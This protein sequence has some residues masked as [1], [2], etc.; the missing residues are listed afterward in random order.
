M[1]LATQR[2]QGGSRRSQGRQGIRTIAPVRGHY[3]KNR[4]PHLSAKMQ[5]HPE[6]TAPFTNRLLSPALQVAVGGRNNPRH[7]RGG[8]EIGSRSPGPRR[9]C[10]LPCGHSADHINQQSQ[11]LIK[12]LKFYIKCLDEKAAILDGGAKPP[13][14]AP[15]WGGVACGRVRGAL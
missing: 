10:A 14:G 7:M 1:R 13:P 8:E 15:Y 4:R 11:I 3:C 12:I 9:A 6:G 5:G 2:L